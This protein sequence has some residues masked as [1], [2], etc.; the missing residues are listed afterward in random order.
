MMGNVFGQTGSGR[1][2]AQPIRRLSARSMLLL[3]G[4]GVLL[5]ALC[6]HVRV[7]VPW[8]IVPMTGQVFAVLICGALLGGRYGALSQ[9]MYLGLGIAGVPWLVAA[10]MK[11]FTAGYLCGFVVAALFLGAMTRRYKWARALRGQIYLMLAAV[12]IIYLFGAAGLMVV[13]GCST[14]TAVSLGIVPFI[15]IDLLKVV[16][17]A[18]ITSRVLNN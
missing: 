2:E 18:M 13:T 7:Y 14:A 5:T 10:P 8:T 9:I 1:I 16:A 6:A 17:A 12:G 15:A 3:T 11:L 4:C